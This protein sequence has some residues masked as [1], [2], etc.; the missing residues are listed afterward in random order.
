[1]RPATGTGNYLNFPK[2]G[3]G[4][5]FIAYLIDSIILTVIGFILVGLPMIIFMIPAMGAGMSQRGEAAAGALGVLGFLVMM[6][7]MV[8]YMVVAILYLLWYWAKKGYTP[9]KKMMG[10]RVITQNGECPIGWGPSFLRLI[11]YFVNGMIMNLGFLFILFDGE[12]RGLHDMIAKT[13]VVKI[14]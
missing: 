9:G 11:G 12:K 3:F 4:V 13:Y 2:A 7:G 14:K 10:L 8:V 5:R 6:V 1:M